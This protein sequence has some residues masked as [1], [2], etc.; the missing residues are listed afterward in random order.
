MLVV[1]IFLGAYNLVFRGDIVSTENVIIPKENNAFKKGSDKIFV[2]AEEPVAGAV[3]NKKNESILYYLKSN[4][5]AY[6]SSLNGD[7]KR[8]FSKDNVEG[9]VDVSW[10]ADANKAIIKINNEGRDIFYFYDHEKKEGSRIKDNVDN[11]VWSNVGNRIIYKY[12]NPDTKERTL[13]IANADG[14]NWEKIADIGFRDVSIAGVPQ[15]SFVSFWNYPKSGTETSLNLV[16]A[17]GGAVENIFNGKYGADYLWSPDGKNAL[18]SSLEDP[19]SASFKLGVIGREKKKYQEIGNSS[20]VSKCIWSYDAVS[21]Y[22]ALPS[23]DELGG[24]TLEDYQRKEIFS[25]DVFWKINVKNG[26]KERIVEPEE[27]TEEYDAQGL[28]LSPKEDYLFFTN[29]ID[30]KLYGVSL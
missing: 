5:N 26:K 24:A 11:V 22:C 17:T 23:G 15:S 13:N 3:I 14:N 4:G 21:I 8:P 12:F 9:L 19:N 1:L 30:G 29:R 20:L 2:V 18:V 28:I 27:I 6:E 16:A 25:K 10:S 7:V